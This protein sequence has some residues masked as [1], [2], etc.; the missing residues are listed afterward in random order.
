MLKFAYFPLDIRV[1]FYRRYQA[2]SLE[3]VNYSFFCGSR[4]IYID[5]MKNDLLVAG[6]ILIKQSLP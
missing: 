5:H 6:A 4:L 1:W 2:L 3:V